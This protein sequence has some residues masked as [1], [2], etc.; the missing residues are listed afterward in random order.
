MIVYDLQQSTKYHQKSMKIT[1][2]ILFDFFDRHWLCFRRSPSNLSILY[3]KWFC[4]MVHIIKK[5]CLSY[6]DNRNLVNHK[7]ADFRRKN[8]Q[9]RQNK[10][11]VVVWSRSPSCFYDEIACCWWYCIE[12]LKIIICLIQIDMLFFDAIWFSVSASS[13]VHSITWKQ[14]WCRGEMHGEVVVL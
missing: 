3:I 8:T 6:P 5:K 10:V 12:I 14:N 11:Y 2:Q 9:D 13:V 1:M 4:F 7:T